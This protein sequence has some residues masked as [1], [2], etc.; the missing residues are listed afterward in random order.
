MRDLHACDDALT[1]TIGKAECLVLFD[2]LSGLRDESHLAIR[3]DA[4]RVTLWMLQASL[5][6]TLMEPFLDE[7]EHTL[8]QARE[9]VLVKWGS[10]HKSPDT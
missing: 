8:Q 1:I 5:E 7:Y 10:P 4:E 2:L 9:E 6:K 3:N